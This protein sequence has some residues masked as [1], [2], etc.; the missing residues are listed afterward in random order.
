MTPYDKLIARKRKWTP[1]QTTAGKL[2]EGAEEAVFRALALRN[3]ELP[4]GEFI[5]AGLK[6]EVPEA[7]QEIL[8]MN[9]L[10]EENHDRA[11][12]YAARAIGTDSKAEAEA[13]ALRQ[14]WED[15]RTIPY[16]KQWY[17]REASSL[18]SSRS[19]ASAETLD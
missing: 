15:H 13:D 2:K 14:A 1:V 11:L 3:L 16:A 12:G 9:V 7:A 5:T 8:L 18:S 17:W 6:G 4:V 10:D 19:F